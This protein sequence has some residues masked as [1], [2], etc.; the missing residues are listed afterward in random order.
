M[1]SAYSEVLSGIQRN[2]LSIH[3]CNVSTSQS[4]YAEG[5]KPD[6]KHIRCG[7]IYIH[8]YKLMYSEESSSGAA[9]EGAGGGEA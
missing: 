5:K 7:S 1:A 4:K 2:E 8:K 9:G 3:N 6:K